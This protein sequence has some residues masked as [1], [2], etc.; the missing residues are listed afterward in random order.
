MTVGGTRSASANRQINDALRG[1][2]L[3]SDE[4]EAFRLALVEAGLPADDIAEV[5]VQPFLF[6]RN[7]KR[8]GYGALEVYGPHVLSSPP[9]RAAK[10]S[11]ARSLNGCWRTP[12]RSAHI[13]VHDQCTRLFRR[14]CP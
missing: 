2:P 11:V 4:V 8:V 9:M 1:E 6:E 13:F 5:G 3:R 7:L 12:R 10:A 14:A